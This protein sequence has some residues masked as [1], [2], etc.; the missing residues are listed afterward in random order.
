MGRPEAM[1][2][3]WAAIKEVIRANPQRTAALARAGSAA[4]VVA[5]MPDVGAKA[6]WLGGTTDW[7]EDTTFS[8]ADVVSL[9]L[10]IADPL[11]RSAAPSVRRIMEMEEATTLIQGIDANWRRL[12]GKGRGWV[13]KHL[14]ED[15]RERSA[16]A[17]PAPDAWELVRNKKRVTQLVDYVCMCKGMRLAL[18]WPEQKICTT[19]PL[20]GPPVSAGV[21]QLNCE[22]GRVL[23]NGMGDYRVTAAMWPTVLTTASEIVWSPP[24]CAPSIGAQTVVQ[25][26]EKMDAVEK[27]LPRTGGRTGMWNRYLWTLLTHELDGI[28]AASLV[29][30]A[31]D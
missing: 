21:V 1:S 27:G 19:I 18:W 9:A 17:D 16:G 28:S 22:S 23:L 13:R 24:L 5:S 10:W 26:Q 3:P 4:A 20:T 15:L 12:N 8:V 6:A 14:E 7:T 31:V 25:I 2:V 11:Y 29:E 30:D